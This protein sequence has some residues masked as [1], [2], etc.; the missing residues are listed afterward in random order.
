[1]TTRIT[2]AA[3]IGAHGLRGEVRLKLFADSPASLAVHK[4]VMIGEREIRLLSVGGLGKSVHARLEGVTDRAGAEALRGA[5]IEVDRA[6]LP[7]LGDGEYY[8]VDL[9]GRPCIDREGNPL[10][11]V[12]AVENYGAG[13]LL[14][15]Q[16]EG[17]RKSLIPFR[18]GIA[19]LDG[20][21]IVIDPLFLA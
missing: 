9:I 11:T 15:V 14:E 20:D 21:R 1:M 8:H 16:A 19:D 18:P 4:R 7:P 3:I 13:D 17:G 5:L 12:F 6:A 10:G 2:L